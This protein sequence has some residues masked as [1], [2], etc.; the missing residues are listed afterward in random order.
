[1]VST[2]RIELGLISIAVIIFIISFIWNN[3]FAALQ[4]FILAPDAGLAS[5]FLYSLTLTIILLSILTFIRNFL[6]TKGITHPLEH[7]P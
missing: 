5:R 1:M 7:K 3:F 4:Q 6:N 2:Y